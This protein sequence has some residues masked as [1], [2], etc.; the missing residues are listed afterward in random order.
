MTV[1]YECIMLYLLQ[2]DSQSDVSRCHGGDFYMLISERHQQP[3]HPLT[4]HNMIQ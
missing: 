4:V 3:A 2:S 1:R